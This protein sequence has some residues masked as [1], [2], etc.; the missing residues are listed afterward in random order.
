M[1]LLTIPISHYCEKARWALARLAL[2]YHEERHV[3]G[4]HYPRTYWVSGGPTVPVLIDGKNIIADSRDIL[5]YLDRY[6]SP[7]TKLYPADN[8]QL[9]QIK[10]LEDLFD[11]ELGVESR[12]WIYFQYLQHPQAMLDIASQ[13]VPRLER[14][15]G[16]LCF[17]LLRA[18]I[19]ARLRVHENEVSAGL[20]RCREIVSQIDSLLADGRK[21]LLGDRFGA[22]DVSLACMM[23]P[24]VLPRQYGIQLPSI[25]E[26]PATMRGT[27]EEFQDTP[28][29][30]FVLRLFETER[31]KI[32][33][34]E[35]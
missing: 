27:V 19:R 15:S 13:G 28:T 35:N 6:A 7:E 32:V 2:T 33:G 26:V 5:K 34:R 23:S 25:E 3:Q 17:P 22:A 18:F 24:F 20:T 31:L 10:K 16:P 30:R 8:A 1:R 11:R 12:R 4:F 29:G 21:F 14:A 9:H